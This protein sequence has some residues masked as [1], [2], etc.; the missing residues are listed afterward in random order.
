MPRAP[1][2]ILKAACSFSNRNTGPDGLFWMHSNAALKGRSSTV[3]PSFGGIG[4][5]PAL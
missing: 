2:D 5:S 4:G 1:I 3:S